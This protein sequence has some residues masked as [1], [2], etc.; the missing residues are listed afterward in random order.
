MRMTLGG[1]EANLKRAVSL[2][3]RAMSSSRTI[4]M[5]CSEGERAV[6]DFSPDGFDA[7]ALDQVAGDVEVDVGL[8]Q[9]HAD[10]A[11]GFGDV[12]FSERALAAEGLEGALEF[13]GKVFK[14]RSSTSVSSVRAEWRPGGLCRIRMRHARSGAVEGGL[15]IAATL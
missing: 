14:H 8:E 2:P 10:F 13:V 15:W 7:D 4:L 12:F 6:E 9:G 5:T 1:W 3:R 11:Q